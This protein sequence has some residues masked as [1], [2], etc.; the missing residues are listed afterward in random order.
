MKSFKAGVI[1]DPFKTWKDITLDKHC[2]HSKT[3]AMQLFRTLKKLVILFPFQD[4]K[5]IY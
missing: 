5:N 1:G 4:I 3:F 2:W